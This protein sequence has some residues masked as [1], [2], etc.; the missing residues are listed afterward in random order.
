M[1]DDG[2]ENEGDVNSLLDENIVSEGEPAH[3]RRALPGEEIKRMD[4]EGG[5]VKNYDKFMAKEELEESR[6]RRQEFKSKFIQFPY[7]WWDEMTTRDEERVHL[8]GIVKDEIGRESYKHT[9]SVRSNSEK[10]ALS[11]FPSKLV[12]QI[13]MMWSW[14]NDNVFDPFAGH[15]TRPILTNHFNRN[16]WG[17]DVSREY[18]GRTKE[19]IQ[20]RVEGGLLDDETMTN[21]DRVIDVNL[22]GNNLRLE[23]RDSRFL[24]ESVGEG[25]SPIRDDW[26]DFVLTSPPYWDLENYGPEDEQLG[27]ANEEFMDF[28]DDMKQVMEHTY[29]ILRDKRYAAFVV[30]DFRKNSMET[31]LYDYHRY[32]IEAAEH[33]GFDLHDIALY[34]TGQSAGI[35]TMQLTH[36]EVTAKI[37]EYILVFRKNESGEKWLPRGI[38]LDCYSRDLMIDEYGEEYLADW[39]ER[40]QERGLDVERW[41]PKPEV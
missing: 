29:R 11:Q 14:E 27:N 5:W 12:K 39:I 23:N 16:Y 13:L 36:M 9:W 20:S 10:P 31:G 41:L 7:S 32:V 8:D 30:N 3:D 38:H 24:D 22:D 15:M 4:V 25:R 34:P 19:K 33:A 28:I 18:W 40:R 2:P 26:A 35:F 17:C 21:T 37:H 6:T 1:S